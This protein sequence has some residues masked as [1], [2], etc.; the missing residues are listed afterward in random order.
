MERDYD[1]LHSRKWAT[2]QPKMADDIRPEV[3][4]HIGKSFVFQC[5]DLGQEGE[6]YAGQYRWFALA[7]CEP[8]TGR[9]LGE[10][11]ED[12]AWWVPDEDLVDVPSPLTPSP[13][14]G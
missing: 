13:H 4:H 7:D 8:A 9:N 3:S 2:F 6:P 5:S 12:F 10:M 11:R 14:S 1:K